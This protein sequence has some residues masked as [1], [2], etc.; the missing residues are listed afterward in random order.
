MFAPNLLNKILSLVGMSLSALFF[1]SCT[2][3]PPQSEEATTSTWTNPYPEGSYDHFKAENYPERSSTYFNQEVLAR[4][5]SSNSHIKISL[6]L[7]RA[8]LMNGDEIAMDY[9]V[10]TGKTTHPTPPGTYSI[11]EKIQDK[12]SNLY[13]KVLDSSGNVVDSDADSRTAKI[14][15]GGKFLGAAMPYWM[16]F[17]WTG[18]GH[19]IG[20]VPRYPASHACIRGQEDILPIVFNKV[21]VGTKAE[22]VE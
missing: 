9:P 7:Q 4:T 17:T 1:A 15:P 22:I 18:I 5:N 16:R 13:G 3:L 11:L 8:F 12:R 21:R 14:P 20:N 2:S 10:S 19:H 6:S